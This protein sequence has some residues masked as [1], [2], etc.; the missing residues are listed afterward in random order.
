MTTPDQFAGHVF[1]APQSPLG[2]SDYR[3]PLPGYASRPDREILVD[4]SRFRYP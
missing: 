3:D 4:E 2:E 1:D